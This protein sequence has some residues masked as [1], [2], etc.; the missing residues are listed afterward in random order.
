MSDGGDE[1]VG[2]PRG[3]PITRLGDLAAAGLISPADMTQ[4]APVVDRFQLRLTEDVA[5]LVTSGAPDDPIARQFVPDIAEATVLPN[6]LADPIGDD[7]HGKVAGI[8]HRYPDRVLLKPTHLCQVYCRFCFRRE[9]VG[10]GRE[11]LSDAEID[12][13]IN[14]I[15]HH[16]EIF[17]VILTGG[18]P[19]VLSDRRLAQI[20][21][22][23]EEIPHVEVVRL[24]TRVVTADPGRIT[25]TLV[26]MLRRRFATWIGV[27]VN[28]V[29]EFT[30]EADAAIARLV[31][32]GIPLVSQ[33]V[34]LKSVND[35][36]EAL[37]DLMR[38]FVKRR[39]K[40]YYLHH[41]DFAEGTNHFRVPLSEGK[42]LHEA[43]RGH[44]TGL[45]QPS[46]ILD[47]P[48]GFGKVPVSEDWIHPL[49]GNRYSIRDWQG[50]THM[51]EEPPTT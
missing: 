33:T 7:V 12:A 30:P 37:S 38:G 18:D 40:P 11:T 48:G 46:Y 3:R 19:L 41:L 20:F 44:V 10:D 51:Y 29:R 34:L 23:L 25:D 21:D 24:H 8:T 39:I 32:G 14:Y 27:H 35:S 45:G 9:K 22:L 28:H 43:L 16:D 15:A 26:K 50:Q 2:R 5:A 13:A 17:E 1:Q 42:A 36:V 6:E 47:I 31:D 49:S 4:L